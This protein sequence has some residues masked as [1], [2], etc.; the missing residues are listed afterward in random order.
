M[1]VNVKY[2]PNSR[3]ALFHACGADEV[4]YGGAKGG[5]KSC[6]LVIEAAAWGYEH[7]GA[8]MYIFRESY[9]DLEANIIKEFKA[10]IPKE[11]YAYSE[12]KHIATLRN[13]TT[14]NFRYISNETDAEGYQGRSMDWIGVDELTKHSQRAVQILL[15]C[16]RSPK[17]FRPLFRATC[18]PGGIGHTWVK[19]RYINPT[20][21]GEATYKDGVTENS[22]AFIPATVYDNDII[23]KND[24]AYV[25]R[26]ENLPD[27]EKRA[28]LFGDWDIF[29]G[30]YFA[31][32][33]REIHVWTPFDIPSWWPRFISLDYGLDCTAALWWAVDGQQRPYIHRELAVSGLTYT[34]AAKAILEAN[35][36]EP[37]DYVVAS[38]DMWNRQRE[39]GESGFELMIRSG[40]RSIIKAN[41]AR[42]PGW[43]ALKEYLLPF[44]DEYGKTRANLAI[45]STCSELIRCLPLLQFDKNNPEDVSGKPHDITHLPES[46]RYGIMSR[47][48]AGMEPVSASPDPFHLNEPVQEGVTGEISDDYIYYGVE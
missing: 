48:Q 47:P 46:L 22:I 42:I 15:S 10:K 45:F 35:N 43:R 4:V 30:Q 7:P 21:K 44:S 17:G 39:S 1:K 32:F 2:T 11:L 3:Q 24:P 20:R 33:R 16:L 40:L 36:G 29:E 27:N 5:G 25:R 13:G 38:P 34:Q 6:A 37:Y 41:N 26:L 8:D 9:D 31:E 23:M 12:T 19:E 18:N 14:I 28:Y